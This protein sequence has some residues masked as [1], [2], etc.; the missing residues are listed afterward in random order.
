MLDFGAHLA[1]IPLCPF[2]SEIDLPS[3]ADAT[4]LALIVGRNRSGKLKY[5]KKN[6][7]VLVMVWEKQVAS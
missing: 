6:H 2:S 3:H 5:N 1:P 4:K 7:G